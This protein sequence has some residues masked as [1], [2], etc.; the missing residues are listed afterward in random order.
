MSH[1]NFYTILGVDPDANQAAIRKAYL[2]LSLKYHPDKNPDNQEEAKEQ[3]IKIGQAYETLSDPSQRAVY[4]RELAT[5]RPS[6]STQYSSTAYTHTRPDKTYE[7][8]REAFDAHVAG[9]SEDELRAASVTASVVGGLVGSLIGAGLGRKVAG[10]SAVGRVIFETAGSLLGSTVGSE[11]GQDLLQ[12]VHTQSRDRISYEERKRVATERGEA[13][14]EKPSEGW[15][16]IF[17]ALNKTAESVKQKAH[18]N[19]DLSSARA[20]QAK[21]IFDIASEVLKKRNDGRTF[22]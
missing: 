21:G 18:G 4:D 22:R 3:F 16:D 10:K 11:A 1:E 7:S 14:P 12:N 19:A 8:Y 17:D 15:S 9:M 2:K 6:A 13:I 20:Q 5:G